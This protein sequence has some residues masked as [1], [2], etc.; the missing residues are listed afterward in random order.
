MMQTTRSVHKQMINTSP[1]PQVE[2]GLR[3]RAR[4][5]TLPFEVERLVREAGNQADG[6]PSLTVALLRDRLVCDP[7]ST[8]ERAIFFD[9][10]AGSKTQH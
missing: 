10:L 4:S 5:L 2:Y 1:G 7:A 3:D 8:A 6:D 9:W